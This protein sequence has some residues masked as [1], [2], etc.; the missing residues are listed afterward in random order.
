M[1]DSGFAEPRKR[2]FAWLVDARG[3][4]YRLPHVA[5]AVA[6]E[7]MYQAAE[8]HLWR[9]LMDRAGAAVRVPLR[10]SRDE[11]LAAF[12]EVP[13]AYQ[14]V[15]VNLDGVQRGDPPQMVVVAAP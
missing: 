14:L 5:G 2:G 4:R 10:V 6:F 9:R 3:H 11:F 13:G 12:G 15:P 1:A 7:V 8:G